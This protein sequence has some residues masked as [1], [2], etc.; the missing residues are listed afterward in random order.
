MANGILF[1]EPYNKPLSALGKFQPGCYRIFYQTGS[2]TVLAPVYKDPELLYPYEQSPAP[3]TADSNGRFKPIFL[4]PTITYHIQLFSSGG[5]LLEDVDPYVQQIQFARGTFQMFGTGFAGQSSNNAVPNGGAIYN[6]LF[7]RLVFLFIP[8]IAGTSNAT[9]FTLTGIP[10][11][12]TPSINGPTQEIKVSAVDN[13]VE[14]AIASLILTPGSPVFQVLKNAQTSD[15]TASGNKGMGE[16]V[17]KYWL[18]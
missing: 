17:V 13:S 12:I 10:P 4:D 14:L 11:I 15:W 6:L 16:Q 1:Y 3:I 2:S 5:V 7:N 18:Y 9:T 8:T